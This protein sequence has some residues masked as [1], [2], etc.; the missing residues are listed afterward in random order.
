MRKKPFAVES[1][2]NK[3]DGNQEVEANFTNNTN[4]R[5]YDMIESGHSDDVDIASGKSLDE[6]SHNSS[7]KDKK[8]PEIGASSS[9]IK[10]EE[11]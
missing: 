1:S 4:D 2:V 5:S 8:E 11:E 3:K 10:V 7:N 6:Q 9:P